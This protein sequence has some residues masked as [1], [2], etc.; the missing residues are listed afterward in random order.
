MGHIPETSGEED[1]MHSQNSLDPRLD[2]HD[3]ALGGREQKGLPTA[4]AEGPG[5]A[6][7]PSCPQQ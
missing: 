2:A 1:G 7:A 4:G 5:P 3:Q 6:C